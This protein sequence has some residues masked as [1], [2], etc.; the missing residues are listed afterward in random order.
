MNDYQI[1]ESQ[2]LFV[3]GS[4]QFRFVVTVTVLLLVLVHALYFFAFAKINRLPFLVCCFQQFNQFY[5]FSRMR[6]SL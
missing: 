1:N 2:K 5:G 3:I 6:I 4:F